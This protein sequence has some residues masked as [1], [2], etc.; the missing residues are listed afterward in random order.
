[1]YCEMIVF[2]YL[3]L[4]RKN[5]LLSLLFF[6]LRFNVIVFINEFAEDKLILGFTNVK[7]QFY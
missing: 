5:I 3:P 4:L 1:M 2:C 6:K 7:N